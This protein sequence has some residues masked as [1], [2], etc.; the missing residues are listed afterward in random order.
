MFAFW[1][2]LA[3][4]DLPISAYI[5]LKNLNAL[6]SGGKHLKESGEYPFSFGAK[7]ATLHQEWMDGSL[8]ASICAYITWY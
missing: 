3:G 4:V 6:R 1:F 2:P 8:A 5:Y 7:V